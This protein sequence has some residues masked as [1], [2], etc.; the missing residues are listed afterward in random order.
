MYGTEVQIGIGFQNSWDTAPSQAGSFYPVPMLSESIA[1]DRPPL[2]LANMQGVYDDITP[3]EGP[4]TIG[5][6][7]ECE[8]HPLALGVLLRAAVGDPT[9]TKANSAD[10]YDHVFVP[11]TSDFDKFAALTP[12]A[13]SKR[14]NDGG[15]ADLFYNMQGASLALN[16][17]NGELLK[18]SFSVMGG[19]YSQSNVGSSAYPDVARAWTWDQTSVSVAAAGISELRSAS[20]VLDNALETFHLLDGGK[21]PGRIKRNAKRTLKVSGSMMFDTRS[22]YQAFKS[23]SERNLKLTFTGDTIS[24]GYTDKLVV[25]CPRFQYEEFKPVTGGAGQIEVSFS[26]RGNYDAGSGHSVK[27]TLT[28][29]KAAY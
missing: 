19:A 6:T 5:D 9:S 20:I 4:H 1:L 27:Y 22:E 16:I 26:G 2:E 7:L 14:W 18:A 28:N 13:I 24:S 15:S 21:D 29:T 8:V 11:G 23:K 10:V 3:K 12:H 17:A 25:E